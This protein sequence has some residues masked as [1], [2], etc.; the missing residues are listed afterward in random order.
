MSVFARC[1]RACSGLQHPRVFNK[2]FAD[3]ADLHGF[4][5]VTGMRPAYLATMTCPGSAPLP[6]CQGN[7]D[8]DKADAGHVEGMELFA[9]KEDGERGADDG[10]KI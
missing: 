7:A 4:G 1:R 10:H 8:Q 9:K 2:G 6:V 5:I 3:R